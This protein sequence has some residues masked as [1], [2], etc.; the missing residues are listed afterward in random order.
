MLNIAEGA[1]KLSAADKRRYYQTARGSATECAALL[2]AS[3][4]VGLVKFEDQRM[5]KEMLLRI[6]AML[7]KL[8][9]S[10]ENNDAPSPE[11][12]PR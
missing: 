7:V 1:G 12:H 2:D 4:R 5:G 10:F 6:V 11:S 8:T 9:R 3:A